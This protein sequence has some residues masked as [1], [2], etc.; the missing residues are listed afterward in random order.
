LQHGVKWGQT[1][2]GPNLGNSDSY[3]RGIHDAC[4]QARF[5]LGYHNSVN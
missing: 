2:G 1:E 3:T 4:L 5:A